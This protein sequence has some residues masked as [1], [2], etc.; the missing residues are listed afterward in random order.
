MGWGEGGGVVG[1]RHGGME[2]VV[3]GLMSWVGGV[4]EVGWRRA[5][6]GRWSRVG[7]GMGW[8]GRFMVREL[9]HLRSL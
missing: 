9:E 3:E 2:A 7:N 5:W 1:G 6:E 8:I 4:S